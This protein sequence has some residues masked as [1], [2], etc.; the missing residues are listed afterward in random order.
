MGIRLRGAI[1]LR[2]IRLRNPSSGGNSSSGAIRLRGIRLR[3]RVEMSYPHSGRNVYIY[4]IIYVYIMY[5]IYP[6][7]GDDR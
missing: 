5:I 6:Y 1:R 2:G 7:V 3:L 4:T